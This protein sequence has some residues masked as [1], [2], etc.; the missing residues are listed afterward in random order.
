MKQLELKR[1]QI[2]NLIAG[3]YYVK[4][5]NTIF[6]THAR[7]LLRLKEDLKKPIVGDWVDVQIIENTPKHKVGYIIKVLPRTNF[8]LRP[9]VANVDQGIIIAS[10]E[11]PFLSTYLIN[12]FIITLMYN[13]IEPIIIFTKLDLVKEKDFTKL[14][15]IYKWYKKHFRSFK[16]SNVDHLG[17]YGIKKIFKK[18]TSVFMGQTGVGKSSTINNLDNKFKIKTAAISKKLGRG[19]HTTRDAKIYK[20]NDGQLI[21]S[22][23]FSSFDLTKIDKFWIA[24]NFF[25][26]VKI[27]GNCK[28]LNCVHIKEP[29]CRIKDALSNNLIPEFIYEDYCKLIAEL[30]N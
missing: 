16:I 5:K 27:E 11:E 14:I 3:F 1:G 12:K 25:A 13:K 26:F 30:N 6:E 7:G 20:F 24:M 9:K 29:K 23:G 19:K 10:L 18:K 21:D 15:N 4:I 22:P 28:Y 2:I 17:F 8:L